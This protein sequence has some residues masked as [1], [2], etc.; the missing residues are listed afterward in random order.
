MSTVYKTHT[1][2]NT[3]TIIIMIVLFTS[4]VIYGT[5]HRIV[6]MVDYI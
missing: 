5:S 1:A 6:I 4:N 2:T 3:I